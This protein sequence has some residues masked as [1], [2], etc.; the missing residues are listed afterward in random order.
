M[1]T[2]ITDFLDGDGTAAAGDVGGSI[3]DDSVVDEDDKG[4][5]DGDD[6]DAITAAL[7]PSISAAASI[8]ERL[9]LVGVALLRRRPSREATSAASSPLVIFTSCEGEREEDEGE[10]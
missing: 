10:R 5:G 2:L 4:D 8:S 6:D 9:A 7:T 3:A 1:T